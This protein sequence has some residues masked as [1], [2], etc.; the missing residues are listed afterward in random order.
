MGKGGKGKK[1]RVKDVDWSADE[2]FDK[3]RSMVYIEHTA[4]CPIFQ[5]KAEAFANF[6]QERFPERMIQL[7]R[8]NNGKLVPRDGS[9][10]IEFSQNART[11]KHNIWS[12]LE[13]GPPRR[14]KF[15]NFESLVP[16]V[17]KI[18]KKFYAEVVTTLDDDDDGQMDM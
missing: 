4:E 18:L 5:V 14:D 15:P 7:V 12:G 3:S 9:F 13:R 1:K 6:L 16:E 8:N 10:E 11:S 17:T 2:H